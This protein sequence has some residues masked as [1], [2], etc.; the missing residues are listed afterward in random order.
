MPARWAERSCKIEGVSRL[1]RVALSHKGEGQNLLGCLLIGRGRCPS[2]HRRTRGAG[3]VEAAA[4]G[5]AGG[6]MEAVSI[7][8]LRGEDEIA[9]RGDEEVEARARFRFRR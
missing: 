6:L 7:A 5:E 2:Q 3:L 4:R 1:V 8:P 9:K